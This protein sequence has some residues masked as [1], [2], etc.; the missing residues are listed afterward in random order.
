MD[1]EVKREIEKLFCNN[2]VD[3]I[4]KHRQQLKGDIQQTQE[5]LRALVGKRYRE[6]LASCE[7]IVGMRSVCDDLTRIAAASPA[8]GRQRD[9]GK[10]SGFGTDGANPDS[11]P[12]ERSIV[13]SLYRKV[14]SI[15]ILLEHDCFVEAACGYKQ[16]K[17]E[18]LKLQSQGVGGWSDSASAKIHSLEAAVGRLP[19]FIYSRIGQ[20][21]LKGSMSS[22]E[23][24]LGTPSIDA[25]KIYSEAQGSIEQLEACSPGSALEKLLDIHCTLLRK[26][27]TESNDA[28]TLQRACLGAVG[29]LTNGVAHAV[30]CCETGS[31]APTP[32]TRATSLELLL[33]LDPHSPNYLQT[34]SFHVDGLRT[35]EGT[36][37]SSLDGWAMSPP[38]A[39]KIRL[40]AGAISTLQA[41]T[42][43]ALTTYLKRINKADVLQS[44]ESAI[45]G[46][47]SESLTQCSIS[48]KPAFEIDVVKSA[49]SAAVTEVLLRLLTENL[50]AVQHSATELCDQVLHHSTS[51]TQQ[52]TVTAQLLSNHEALTE[53]IRRK[54]DPRRGKHGAA[55]LLTAGAPASAQPAKD[56]K[57]TLNSLQKLV[58]AVHRIIATLGGRVSGSAALDA[59]EKALDALLTKVDQ[60]LETLR[61][62]QPTQTTANGQPSASGAAS[63]RPAGDAAEAR[64]TKI[65]LAHW[66]LLELLQESTS[67]GSIG[68]RFEKLFLKCHQS[69]MSQ[70]IAA[71]GQSLNASVAALPLSYSSGS[72]AIRAL[73]SETW[74]TTTDGGVIIHYPSQPSSSVARALFNLQRATSEKLQ[75]AQR[76]VVLNSLF[77]S[78]KVEVANYVDH[79]G[80]ALKEGSPEEIVLQLYFDVLALL[81]IFRISSSSA[82]TNELPPTI[83]ALDRLVES[84]VDA[85]TWTLCQP[86]IDGA[87]SKFLKSTVLSLGFGQAVAEGAKTPSS[88]HQPSAQPATSQV[89][90]IFLPELARF[91]LLPLD[92]P[93]SSGGSDLASLS[94]APMLSGNQGP[95][96]ASTATSTAAE[97]FG[98]LGKGIRSALGYF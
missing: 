42:I 77:R 85:I 4:V 87:I 70:A 90:S 10:R 63:P 40:P 57:P 1:P 6:L 61:K 44:T 94:S 79:V 76:S 12:D 95:S 54:V 84:R 58:S 35:F 96:S 83:P 59:V 48:G 64:L 75:G 3:Q 9:A 31:N 88:P 98:T 38:S 72:P 30:S 8:K 2:T 71:F 62:G 17:Q 39:M 89:G 81:Q 74:S 43:T 47:F 5:Q 50:Q 73:Y 80:K 21:L 33:S 65:L 13:A 11:K 56:E 66:S 19:Q 51:Q 34:I 45:M 67:K 41:E 23:R 93:T 92:L 22:T 49:V 25:G 55:A 86:L 15:H 14:Y 37:N 28:A 26:S 20:S 82:Q 36:G 69:W 46:A 24:I 60:T 91:A 52:Q 78:L 32:A 68:D 29:L 53:I 16:V 7:M 18:L 97:A 27:I